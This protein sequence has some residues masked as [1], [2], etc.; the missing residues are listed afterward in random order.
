[1]PSREQRDV[2]S[3]ILYRHQSVRIRTRVPNALQAIALGHGLRRGSSLWSE[4]GQ[5]AMASLS[6]TRY[7]AERRT[8]LQSLY[9]HLEKQI[10]YLRPTTPRGSDTRGAHLLWQHR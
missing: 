6:L 9:R 1:M 7:R 10:E 2:R 3:L 4:A 8:A 5:H